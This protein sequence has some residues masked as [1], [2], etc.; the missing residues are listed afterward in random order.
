MPFDDSL[1][2]IGDISETSSVADEKEIQL[3]LHQI[4][5]ILNEQKGDEQFKK[6]L[7]EEES[8]IETGE[9]RERFIQD[10]Y[11]EAST[12]EAHIFMIQAK[13]IANED[14]EEDEEFRKFFYQAKLAQQK[15]IAREEEMKE[16]QRNKEEEDRKEARK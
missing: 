11:D 16:N 14:E 13:E 7:E 12:E 9:M 15:L 6:A 4:L 5:H 8:R 2:A 10:I 1:S 3:K